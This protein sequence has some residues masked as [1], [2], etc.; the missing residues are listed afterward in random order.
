MAIL[1]Q[2]HADVS[3]LTTLLD[4]VDVCP[5][6]LRVCGRGLNRSFHKGMSDISIVKVYSRTCNG[7]VKNKL[8]SERYYRVIALINI[9]EYCPKL[10][11]RRMRACERP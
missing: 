5:T 7:N 1:H 3:K 10:G 4:G 2:R 9:G 6:K 11:Y 8:L